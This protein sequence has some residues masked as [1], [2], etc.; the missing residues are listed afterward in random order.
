MERTQVQSLHFLACTEE[1]PGVAHDCRFSFASHFCCFFD[2]F[3]KPSE[4]F[5]GS[6]EAVGLFGEGLLLR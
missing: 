1:Q 5:A 4:A 3:R 2:P 6:S